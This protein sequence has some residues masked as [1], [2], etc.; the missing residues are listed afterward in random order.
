MM[1]KARPKQVRK[2]FCPEDFYGASVYIELNPKQTWLAKVTAHY[3]YV[4]N[5]GLKLR[6]TPKMFY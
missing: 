1:I 5:G 4:N 2:V 3:A 6:I